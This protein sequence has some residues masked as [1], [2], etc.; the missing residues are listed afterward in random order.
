MAK[1][2]GKLTALRKADLERVLSDVHRALLSAFPDVGEEEFNYLVNAVRGNVRV[3]PDEYV[4]YEEGIAP[5]AQL[6]IRLQ[7]VREQELERARADAASQVEE[8]TEAEAE[9][10]LRARYWGRIRRDAA[11][12]VRAIRDKEIEDRDSLEQRIGEETDNAMIYTRDAYWTVV[13]TDSDDAF[14]DMNGGDSVP[15]DSAGTILTSLASAAYQED[16]REQVQSEM[17]GLDIEDFLNELADAEDAE[18]A[19]GAEDEEDS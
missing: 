4:N 15:G 10:L 18:G 13:F 2:R 12:I 11:D 17:G 9:R 16:L 6:N 8:M 3:E 1:R 14:F 19:E 7:P 5:E